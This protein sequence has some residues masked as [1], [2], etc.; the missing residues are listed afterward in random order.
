MK[1]L[2]SDMQHKQSQFRHE[3][4]KKEKENHKLKERL[5]VALTDRNKDKKL[6]EYKLILSNITCFTDMFRSSDYKA[7]GRK[8]S[9]EMSHF[10]FALWCWHTHSHPFPPKQELQH[11]STASTQN[12]MKGHGVSWQ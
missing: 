7:S 3:I 8:R 12:T 6:G 11:G 4:R 1:R 10:S 9:N 2:Q 5:H